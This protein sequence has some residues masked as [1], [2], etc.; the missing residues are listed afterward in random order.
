M[1]DK[2]AQIYRDNDNQN[3]SF[4]FELTEQDK[5]EQLDDAF[6]PMRQRKISDVTSSGKLK[7]RRQFSTNRFTVE[8]I[9]ENEPLGGNTSAS[10]SSS[11]SPREGHSGSGVEF[12]FCD[13]IPM[14]AKQQHEQATPLDSVF[15]LVSNSQSLDCHSGKILLQAFNKQRALNDSSTF[16]KPTFQND[17]NEAKSLAPPFLASNHTS[18]YSSNSLKRS[19]SGETNLRH[20]SILLAEKMKVNHE[21]SAMPTNKTMLFI[22]AQVDVCLISIE[23]HKTVLNKPFLNITHC[24]QGGPGNEDHFALVV[25]EPCL[26]N[27]YKETFVVHVFKCQNRTITDELLSSLRQA[28]N[29]AYKANKMKL[30]GVSSVLTTD[31]I[32]QPSADDVDSAELPYCV[33]CPMNWFHN[34]CLDVDGLDDSTVCAFLLFRIKQSSSD[35]KRNEFMTILDALHLDQDGLRVDTLMI[36]LKARVEKMQRKHEVDGCKLKGM[37]IYNQIDEQSNPVEESN[38]QST[39]SLTKLEGLRLM[40]KNSLTNI[41]KVSEFQLF[42]TL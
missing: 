27:Y 28:F 37:T 19:S 21:C 13:P 1:V 31:M 14:S 4:S 7:S 32:D 33:N 16:P 2:A 42:L 18:S 5:Q 15:S 12:N 23:N 35:E 29:N 9:D 40:A 30:T 22:I 6:K 26:P 20:D 36:L 8:V 39:S 10:T 41:F 3:D 25:R 17:Q 38:K 34:L 11:S 24:C